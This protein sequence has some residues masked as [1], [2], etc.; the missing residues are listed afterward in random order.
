VNAPLGAPET[1]SWNN[2]KQD[3]VFVVESTGGH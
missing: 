3:A 2:A 1:V